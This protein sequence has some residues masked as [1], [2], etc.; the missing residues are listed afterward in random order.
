MVLPP[1]RYSDVAVHF[2]HYFRDHEYESGPLRLT[3]VQQYSDS[4]IEEVRD[5]WETMRDTDEYR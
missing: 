5:W 2:A 1:F 4:E 3:S